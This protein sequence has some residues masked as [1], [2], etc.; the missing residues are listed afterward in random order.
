[1]VKDDRSG[2]TDV[3]S[4]AN[5]DSPPFSP[6]ST[7]SHRAGSLATRDRASG[8][9]ADSISADPLDRDRAMSTIHVLAYIICRNVSQDI[10]DVE[11]IATK[12]GKRCRK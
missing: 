10:D 2:N 5:V 11:K 7:R 8:G 6:C 4:S 3:M 1:M 12:Y 9:C